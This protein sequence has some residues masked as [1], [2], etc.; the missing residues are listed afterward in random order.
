MT[1]SEAQLVATSRFQNFNAGTREVELRVDTPDGIITGRGYFD[2]VTGAGLARFTS[3]ASGSTPTSGGV[4]PPST[5]IWWTFDDMGELRGGVPAPELSDAIPR[6]DIDAGWVFSPREELVDSPLGALLTVTA[7]YSLDRPDNPKLIEQSDAIWLGT[8]ADDARNTDINV[9]LPS[10]DVA[11]SEG[12]IPRE[13]PT[14]PRVEIDAEGMV[15]RIEVG[16]GAHGT[17]IVTYGLSS[18]VTI[19]VPELSADTKKTGGIQ[20]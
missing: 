15:W 14:I 2:Y 4:E 11:R 3:S 20:E 13:N 17:G 16:S 9:Q 19:P 12:S 7:G 8:G 10:A 6:L 1:T 5:L 18:A